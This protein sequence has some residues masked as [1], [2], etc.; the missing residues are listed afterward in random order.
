MSDSDQLG[1][2]LV[3][4]F[5]GVVYREAGAAPWQSL[6]DLQARVPDYAGVIDLELMLDEAEGYAYLRQRAQG[7]DAPG[8][9]A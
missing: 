8:C 1:P 5:Q 7:P 9:R 6:L 2:T 3:A 4:L